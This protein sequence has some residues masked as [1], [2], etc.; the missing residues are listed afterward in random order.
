MWKCSVPCCSY[1]I[2]YAQGRKYVNMYFRP[3]VC[4]NIHS[5]SDITKGPF[6]G[7]RV[8]KLLLLQYTVS[9]TSLPRAKVKCVTHLERSRRLA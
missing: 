1:R 7:F 9:R 4:Q 3:E 5:S 6:I 8:L 2:Q